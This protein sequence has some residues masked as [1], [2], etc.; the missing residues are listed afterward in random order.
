MS[1]LLTAKL[2]EFNRPP[3]LAWLTPTVVSDELAIQAAERD[4]V[5]VF[6]DSIGSRDVNTE[7][8]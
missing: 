3:N 7:D 4:R 6:M 5:K 1:Q 2:L 8:R